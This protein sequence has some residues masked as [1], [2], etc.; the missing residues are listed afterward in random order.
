M[1]L[2]FRLEGLE[3]LKL[4]LNSLP[5][6]LRNRI[7][8]K[9]VTKGARI[10]LKSAQ[11]KVVERTGQLRKSLGVKVKTYRA[12]PFAGANTKNA[13]GTTVAIIGARKGFD[14]EVNGKKVNPT[15]Y[16]HLVE[17]GTRP[18]AL[19][20]FS[21]LAAKVGVVGGYQ[22]GRMHKGAEA[23]P[24]LRPAYDESKAAAMR[25]I[26]NGI[27]E[28]LF[29]HVAQFRNRRLGVSVGRFRRAA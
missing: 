1:K 26:V 4:R 5:I 17:F 18:H 8:R 14:I 7:V 23:K 29:R 13:A 20:E 16:A 21:K 2:Q 11:S 25:A 3:D 10:I 9:A 24:F 19:G 12:A 6:A 22:H 15:R 27:K 28:G